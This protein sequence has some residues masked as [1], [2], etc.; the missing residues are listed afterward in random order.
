MH[1]GTATRGSAQSEDPAVVK[2]VIV[3]VKL[4][5]S[6]VGHNLAQVQPPRSPSLTVH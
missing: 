2:W 3:R 6:S 4:R 5:W 1:K